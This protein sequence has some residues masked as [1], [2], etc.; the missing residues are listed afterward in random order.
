MTTKALQ[1]YLL[2][3]KKV[4]KKAEMGWD[5]VGG[6][7]LTAYFLSYLPYPPTDFTNAIAE[8]EFVEKQASPLQ[9]TAFPLLICSL[10]NALPIRPAN[11][12][13]IKVGGHREFCGRSKF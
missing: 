8:D 9:Y 2:S 13:L 11:V 4:A 12:K 10:F 1:V 3:R 6:L 7:D 5:E